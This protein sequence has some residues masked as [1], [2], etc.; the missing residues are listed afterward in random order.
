MIRVLG[1]K[2]RVQLVVLIGLLALASSIG[3]SVYASHMARRQIERDQFSLQRQLAHQ[4]A[5]QLANDMSARARELMFLAGLD[6]LR[7]PS[8]AAGDKA[9]MLMQMQRSYPAYAWIG[10]TDAAGRILASTEPRLAG[11]DVSARSWFRHGRET[12]A[13]EDIH[14]AILLARLLPPPQRDELPLRL[15]DISLPLHDAQGRFIGV[16]A[17]HLSMDWTYELRDLLL[18]QS[19][20][21]PVDLVLLNRD[22]QV[23]VGNPSLPARPAQPL[24]LPL[25]QPAF[26]GQVAT[27][28][29]P[30]P[31]GRRYLTTATPA[32]GNDLFP[33]L[34]WVVAVRTAE[35]VAFGP[36]TRLTHAMLAAGVGTALLFSLAI[37]HLVGRQLRPLERVSEAARQWAANGYAAA[38]PTPEGEGEVAVFT[39]SMTDLVDAL[40]QSRERFQ[41]LFDHAPVAMALVGADGRVRTLNEQFTSLFGYR[42]DQ[43]PDIDRWFA[44]AFPEGAPREAALAR[45]RQAASLIGA[46]PVPVPSAEYGIRRADGNDC[47]IEASGIALPDGLLVSFH[48]LTE[49]RQAEASLRLWAEAFERSEVGLVVVDAITDTIVAANPAFSRRR[50][51]AAGALTGQPVTCLF[52][53]HRQRDGLDTAQR[54]A[55]VSHV[56]FESEHIT[57]DGQVFPVLV[58]ITVLRDAQGKAI[59]RMAYAL[60]LTEHK[61][62]EQEIRRLNAELE[63]RVLER[64]AELSAANRELDSFAYSVSHDLRAPL[65]TVN[66]YAQILENEFADRLGQEGKTYL[67]R[68]QAGTVKMTELIEGL[69]ALSRY[70]KTALHRETV[71]LS[72]LAR[73]R[74][75]E[76]AAAEPQRTVTVE[77]EPGLS[78]DCDAGLADA[79]ITNLVDNAWKYTGKTAHAQIRVHAGAV[80][81]L[82]GICVSDNG[83]GFDM[84]RSQRLFEPFQRLHR[85]SDF[86]GTGVGLATVRR[87]V[88]RHGGRI[89]VQAA[90]GQGA[91]FCFTLRPDAEIL[92]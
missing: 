87:I 9:A 79:L 25:L 16:L 27:G 7:D 52:P 41:Y 85:A 38:L 45:W 83:A 82:Q 1:K 19:G 70:T 91:S 86:Q 75:D 31:D 32:L 57:R 49:R 22:S 64:T 18:S 21:V 74:L 77:I 62:A 78:A 59:K 90:P 80:D 71:D 2:L 55:T 63:Q 72:A 60:D 73:R 3:F 68:I 8:R 6:R 67:E 30:W 20:A 89:T 88:D 51:Y 47:I 43:V 46:R 69:L 48:D 24:S 39:R 34:G 81:G 35:D 58:D 12:L 11:A 65:R 13:F 23:I 28:L 56:V 66:G 33:G 17:A 36:A 61:R 42:L 92:G 76:L 5:R 50:G 53:P 37:W 84:A 40:G 14:N 15:M 10:V 4:M 29:A 44:R 54:T 26:A